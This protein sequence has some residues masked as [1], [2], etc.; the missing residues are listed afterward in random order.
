MGLR[1]ILSLAI[2]IAAALYILHFN[3]GLIPIQIAKGWKIELPF[4]MVVLVSAFVGA[5]LASI[6]GWTEAGLSGLARWKEGRRLRR[7]ERAL[8]YLSEAEGLRTKGRIKAARRRARKACRLD[9]K[10]A[11]AYMLAG[12]LA[13]EAGD[14]KE[15]IRYNERLY[16][17]SPESLET[18]VRL[19][20][21]LE[22][23]GRSEDAEKILVR[24]GEDGKVHPDVLRRLRDM[25]SEQGR[26][27]EALA[28][29]R[30]LPGFWASPAQRDADVRIQGDLLIKAAEVRLA[31]SQ[32]KAALALLEEAIQCTPSEAAPR[33]RLGD[34]NLAIGRQ[35]RAIKVWEEGYRRLGYSTFLRRIVSSYDPDGNPKIM[36]QA[37]SAM[38]S[39]GRIR[40]A[41]P[42]PFVMASALYFEAGATEEGRK[43]LGTASDKAVAHDRKAADNSEEMWLSVMLG[44]F[45]A[46]GKL[47]AGDR[48]AAES[49]FQ[50]VAEEASRKLLGTPESRL[51]VHHEEATPSGV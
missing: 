36:R 39:C 11:P 25:F 30:K 1:F 28:A 35:K 29:G 27:D 23:A 15:A 5:F 37:A 16:S 42:M 19:S 41:D 38:L 21:N 3:R 44:L 13:A 51:V 14:L 48:L 10:L 18:L 26:W 45:E 20:S 24:M 9:S 12:D 6:L 4:V 34:A 31:N 8:S 32:F 40:E 50:K 17:L 49:A 33:L 2:P 22:A 46:R 7:K 43:W 47:E